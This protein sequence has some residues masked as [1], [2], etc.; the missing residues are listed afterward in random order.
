GKHRLY[1]YGAGQEGAELQAD[2][3]DDRDQ[4]VLQRVADDDALLAQ[5]FGARGDQVLLA[6]YFE[7]GAA[8][9][10]G[11]DG[12]G[13]IADGERWQDQSFPAFAAGGW[14]PA[15]SQRKDQQQDQAEPEARD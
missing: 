3:G 6:E 1:D 9:Q 7:H 4:R 15:E 14:E 2:D 5:A 10:S 11:D 8:R 13:A 12:R